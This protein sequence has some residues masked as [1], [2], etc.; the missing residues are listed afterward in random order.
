MFALTT[1]YN[2]VKG[3]DDPV[4]ITVLCI[5]LAV[6]LFVFAWAIREV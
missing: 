4:L 3:S 6:S 2:S 5:V 1:T